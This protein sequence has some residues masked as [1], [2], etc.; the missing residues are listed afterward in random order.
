ME[1]AFK[2]L[3]RAALKMATLLLAEA[4]STKLGPV[5]A[6]LNGGGL[7]VMELGPLPD[8]Q[9]VQIVLVERAGSRQT[10]CSI[11]T[12]AKVLQ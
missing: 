5:E 3:H 6:A 2:D 10:V 7:L 12:T 11:S 4:D 8:P 9:R 1:Q